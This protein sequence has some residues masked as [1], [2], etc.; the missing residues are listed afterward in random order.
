MTRVQI[1]PEVEFKL[2][3]ELGDVDERSRD[4]DLQQHK[5]EVYAA[6]EERL[7]K[8]FPEGFR[9]HDLEFGLDRGWD[10]EASEHAKDA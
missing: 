7:R 8:A 6:F 2:E 3:V 10:N 1:S 5:P 4:Y 9:I